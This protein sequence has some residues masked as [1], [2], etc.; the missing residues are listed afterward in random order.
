MVYGS[1]F[2]VQGEGYKGLGSGLGFK[3]LGFRF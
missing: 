1:W 3:V 2:G